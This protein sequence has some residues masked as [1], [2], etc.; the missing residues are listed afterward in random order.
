[1]IYPHAIYPEFVL[2]I[3]RKVTLIPII[4]YIIPKFNFFPSLVSDILIYSWLFKQWNSYL[5]NHKTNMNITLSWSLITMSV[6]DECHLVWCVI[7]LLVNFVDRWCLF[8]SKG[9]SKI[10]ISWLE[11]SESHIILITMTIA[12]M[13]KIMNKIWCVILD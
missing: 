4:W 13:S 12:F 8:F 11:W 10:F 6:F 1:M 5:N 7:L 2:Y 3:G 9:M